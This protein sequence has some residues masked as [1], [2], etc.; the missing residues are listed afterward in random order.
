MWYTNVDV[1]NKKKKKQEDFYFH[2][3]FSLNYR[4][5]KSPVNRE[6]GRHLELTPGGQLAEKLN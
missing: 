3:L 1:V 6:A 2:S 5:H 4:S